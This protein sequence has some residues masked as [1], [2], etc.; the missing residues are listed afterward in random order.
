MRNFKK[1]DIYLVH[2][3]EKYNHVQFGVRPCII[4]QNDF[5]NTFSNTLI[6][7]PITTKIKKK[8]MPVHVVINSHEMALCECILTISKNQV[9]NYIET[10]NSSSMKLID[11]DLVASLGI[12]EGG[13]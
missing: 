10:L 3:K 4:V 13:K 1:G 12:V 5:G 2:L 9:I 6:V 7:V 8:E 11:T